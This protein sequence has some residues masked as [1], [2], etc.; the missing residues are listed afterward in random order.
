MADGQR[1]MACDQGTMARGRG[2]GL[3]GQRVRVRGWRAMACDQGTMAR[4]R[5][6]GLG[7]RG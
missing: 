4:K 6:A 5:G 1:A 3:R 2:A 7:L